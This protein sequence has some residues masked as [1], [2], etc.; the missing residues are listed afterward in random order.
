[1]SDDEILESVEKDYFKDSD[2]DPSRHELKVKEWLFF[3]FFFDIK[4][5]L[6]YLY[7]VL[8]TFISENWR[9]I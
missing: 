4:S 2:F 5:Y 6:V 8:F 9:E 7:P 3:F 1:M